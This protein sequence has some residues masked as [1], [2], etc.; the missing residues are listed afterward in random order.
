MVTPSAD[1]NQQTTL[2]P[3][4]NES[5]TGKYYNEPSCIPAGTQL[6]LTLNERYRKVATQLVETSL[7][8]VSHYRQKGP[9]KN[10]QTSESNLLSFGCPS[11]LFLVLSLPLCQAGQCVLVAFP[12]QHTREGANHRPI[13][14]THSQLL[15]LCLTPQICT[16]V[17]LQSLYV[18]AW[19]CSDAECFILVEARASS[20]LCFLK[21]WIY[22]WS[23]VCVGCITRAIAGLP[24]GSQETG[25][26]WLVVEASP[27]HRKHS[28]AVTNEAFRGEDSNAVVN[29]QMSC[30]CNLCCHFT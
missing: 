16:V 2:Y 3:M 24:K 27:I 23:L 30:D 6:V 20:H 17:S 12:G 22:E 26:R 25:G 14:A 5:K 4:M 28:E 10:I 18:T 29:L 1:G 19:C 7:I 11:F 8:D 21:S 13:T 9:Q 15:H